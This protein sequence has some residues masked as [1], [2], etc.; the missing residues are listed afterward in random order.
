MTIDSK[1][2]GRISIEDKQLIRFPVGIF[3]FED[4]RNFA[5]LDAQQAPFYWLQSLKDAQIAFVLI[6][7]YVFRSDYVLDIPEDDVRAIGSPE[8]DDLLVFSIVT[9]P[10]DRRLMTANLQG[11]IIINRKERLGRQ[12]I[13]LSQK[14]NTRHVILE[15]LQRGA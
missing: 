9:I 1:A 14:W 15:E 3:G 4:L 8:A 6:N 11:P 13:S 2:F 12:S 7:P 10:Q 5:L